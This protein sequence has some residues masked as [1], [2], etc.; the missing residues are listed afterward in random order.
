MNGGRE[1]PSQVPDDRVDYSGLWMVLRK[2]NIAIVGSVGLN[3]VLGPGRR[4]LTRMYLLQATSVHLAINKNFN[5][6]WNCMLPVFIALLQAR[7]LPDDDEVMEQARSYFGV[8]RAVADGM[9]A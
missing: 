8:I 5:S 6:H 2:G 7:L 3:T 9:H 4:I 1:G